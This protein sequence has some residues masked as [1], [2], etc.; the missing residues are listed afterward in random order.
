MAANP[1]AYVDPLKTLHHQLIVWRDLLVTGRDPLT[2]VDPRDLSIAVE[3]PW[4]YLRAYAWEIALFFV[5]ALLITLAALYLSKPVAAF[6]TALGV[7]G[8]TATVALG[9]VKSSLQKVAEGARVA[10]IRDVV[11]QSA[12]NQAVQRHPYMALP[13]RPSEPKELAD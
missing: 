11:K 13:A 10:A 12:V 6:F 3:S 4:R 7:A 8:I 2:M 9:W 1:D 5:A